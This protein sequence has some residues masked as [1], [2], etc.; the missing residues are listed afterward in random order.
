MIHAQE[1]FWKYPSTSLDTLFLFKCLEALS[2]GLVV[3]HELMY[4]IFVDFACQFICSN[5]S[6]LVSSLPSTLGYGFN[7]GSALLL[8]DNPH[9][10]EIGAL[11]AVNTFLASSGGCISSLIAKFIMTRSREGHAY[12]DLLA[13]MNGALAGM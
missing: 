13:G 4:R 7:S 9:Q 3:S 2:F 12:F 6:V 10:A 8:M 11:C 1:S 5:V